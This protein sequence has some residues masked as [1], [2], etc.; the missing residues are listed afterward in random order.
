MTL[1]SAGALSGHSTDGCTFIGSFSPHPK[2]NVF[3]AS[4]T[5]GGGA[6]IHGT[7]TVTGI[8]FYEAATQRLFS[9]GLNGT[10]TNGFFFIGTKL[11]TL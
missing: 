8:A 1:D 4:V 2:G 11:S 3:N 6:C 10:R 7:D 9:A 5:F